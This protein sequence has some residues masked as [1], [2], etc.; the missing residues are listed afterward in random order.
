M[1]FCTNITTVL[2]KQAALTHQK[3]RNR[4]RFMHLDPHPTPLEGTL[5]T[6]WL[7]KKIAQITHI[8]VYVGLY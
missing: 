7:G 4:V 1:H 8:F 6:R 2:Q 3:H 5:T